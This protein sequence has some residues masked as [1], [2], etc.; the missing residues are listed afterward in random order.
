MTNESEPVCVSSTNIAE[1][2]LFFE[3]RVS[4]IHSV[5]LFISFTGLP[6][7]V[8]VQLDLSLVEQIGGFVQIDSFVFPY[9][10]ASNQSTIYL[11]INDIRHRYHQ[12]LLLPPS[13]I[14]RFP[15]DSPVSQSYG[16]ISEQ[17]RENFFWNSIHGTVYMSKW[18]PNPKDHDLD[19]KFLSLD[20]LL[21]AKGLCF[22][23]LF[24]QSSLEYI[25]SNYQNHFGRQFIVGDCA[26]QA[27]F[28]DGEIPYLQLG[29]PG[30]PAR[31]WIP[32]E[33]KSSRVMTHDERLFINCFLLYH[34]HGKMTLSKEQ[35][36]YLEEIDLDV[37]ASPMHLFDKEYYDR[38]Q[39][40]LFVHE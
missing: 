34:G 6:S 29:K 3:K 23:Q 37:Q 32:T 9:I 28:I 30:H 27:G 22:V 24:E 36:W 2:R 18:L 31:T 14:S 15:P 39:R 12:Y 19:L 40:R 25:T 21:Q 38:Q 13:C 35:R 16:A 4:Y 17:A 10:K 33:T 26:R 11:H 20:I 7:D 1:R 8:F 5:V